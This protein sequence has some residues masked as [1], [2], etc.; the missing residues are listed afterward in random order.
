MAEDDVAVDADVAAGASVSADTDD[1]DD[2]DDDEILLEEITNQG[3][4][5]RIK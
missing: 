4:D 2:D 5:D 3:Q 1:D